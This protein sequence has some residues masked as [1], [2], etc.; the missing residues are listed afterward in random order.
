MIEAG[1]ELGEDLAAA[2]VLA[3]ERSDA[4]NGAKREM[5]RIVLREIS[6]AVEQLHAAGAAEALVNAYE[7]ACRAACRDE[8]LRLSAPGTGRAAA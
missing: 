1:A 8:L 3:A 6:R 2:L 5:A 7:R 4:G